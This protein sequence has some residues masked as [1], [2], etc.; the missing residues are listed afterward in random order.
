MIKGHSLILKT[1]K[2]SCL[3]E[4]LP[5]VKLTGAQAFKASS[6]GTLNDVAITLRL[7]HF[8]DNIDPVIVV[9][10]KDQ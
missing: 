3:A 9:L 6:Y 4:F 8:N 7:F 5:K 10:H 2:N 1:F